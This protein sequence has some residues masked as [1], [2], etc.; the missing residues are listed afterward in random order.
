MNNICLA[1]NGREVLSNVSWTVEA[2]ES[3]LLTGPNGSGKT[4]LMNLI[5]GDEPRGYGQDLKLF[6]R[7]KGSGES[8]AEI[9]SRIGQVSAILQESASRHAPPEEIVGSGLRDAMV[10]TSPLDGYETGLVNRWLKVLG[11]ES[12]QGTPFYRL[13]YGDR[14][15]AMIGRAMIKHPPLLLLDEPM[16]G[17]DSGARQRVADLV[18]SLI[19]ETD[20]TVLFVSHRPGDAPKSITNHIRLIPPADGGPSKAEVDTDY[21]Q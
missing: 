6:E 10:L 21:R 1:Y 16:H 18:D 13:S 2:G 19:R 3:W 8:T 14:R 4:T 20:T 9:K 7:R 17:L 11:L 12:K 5:S 15:L